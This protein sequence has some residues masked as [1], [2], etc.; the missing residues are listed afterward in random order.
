M[1]QETNIKLFGNYFVY[2]QFVFAA[3]CQGFPFTESGL[4]PLPLSEFIST[5]LVWAPDISQKHLMDVM[6]QKISSIFSI[7][8]E[9]NKF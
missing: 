5:S 7:G 3:A 2:L 9:R 4:I 1:I 8:S 6:H